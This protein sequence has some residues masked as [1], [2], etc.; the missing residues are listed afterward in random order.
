MTKINRTQIGNV[1]IK[2]SEKLT[3][4]NI[5]IFTKYGHKKANEFLLTQSR[6]FR[7]LFAMLW[8]QYRTNPQKYYHSDCL[9]TLEESK[10]FKNFSLLFIYKS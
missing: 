2:T 8:D 3:Q 7:A 6:D 5:N 9:E 4:F 10:Y 1:V